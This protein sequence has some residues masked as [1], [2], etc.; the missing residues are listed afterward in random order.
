MLLEIEVLVMPRH[1]YATLLQTYWK[2]ELFFITR[3]TI[4]GEGEAHW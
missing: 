3:C 1:K 4:V 2:K